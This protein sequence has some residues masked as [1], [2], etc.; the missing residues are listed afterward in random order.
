[1][2][3]QSMKRVIAYIRVSTHGQVEG[4]GLDLQRMQI[5]AFAKERSYRVFKEFRDVHTG[6]G[7]D[8]ISDRPGLQAAIACAKKKGWMIIVSGYDRLSRHAETFDE[9]TADPELTIISAEHGVKADRAVIRSQGIRHQ[10]VG[11]IIAKKTKE[12]LKERKAAGKQLGNPTNLAEVQKLGAAGNK[13]R[14]EISALEYAPLIASIDPE[15]K[16]T[17]KAIAAALNRKGRLTPRGKPWTAGNVRRLLVGIET[18]RK[19]N[20]YRSDSL[21]GIFA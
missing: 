4:Q 3:A 19:N 6:M 2:V 13:H 21:F 8:S 1:M 18:V 10:R 7:E 14:A 15:G 17:K 11:D 9:L 20:F 16:L 12:A 5:R